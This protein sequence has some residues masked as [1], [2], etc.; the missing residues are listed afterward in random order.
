MQF[1]DIRCLPPRRRRWRLAQA[2][3]RPAGFCVAPRPLLRA[4]R[5]LCCGVM[6]LDL[7]W[8]RSWQSFGPVAG[9]EGP[10]GCR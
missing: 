3:G 5:F 2:H 10:G 9:P 6:C 1:A 4:P 8:V 7:P